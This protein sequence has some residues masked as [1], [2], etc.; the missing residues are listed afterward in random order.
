MVSGSNEERF[1]IAC[2]IRGGVFSSDSDKAAKE[3]QIK[4]DET[5]QLAEA[6]GE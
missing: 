5:R 6:E 2:L 3:N 4:V 1:A